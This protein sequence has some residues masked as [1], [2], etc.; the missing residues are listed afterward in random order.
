MSVF[1]SASSIGSLW[2]EEKK[3]IQ[4]FLES[5][6]AEQLSLS[7][8][9]H[10]LLSHT[11]HVRNLAYFVSLQIDEKFSNLV[12]PDLNATSA[13][14]HDHGKVLQ[15]P[16]INT[17]YPHFIR[18]QFHLAINGY[19]GIASL[20]GRHNF[21]AL[22]RDSVITLE[23]MILIYA[24]V[25]SRT[26]E[27][28]KPIVRVYRTLN[29]AYPGIRK[30]MLDSGKLEGD[31]IDAGFERLKQFEGL[32][33]QFGID[34]DDLSKLPD[35][36]TPLARQYYNP[37][38][39]EK[40][41]N[42]LHPKIEEFENALDQIGVVSI[43]KEIAE[44]ADFI[45]STIRLSVSGDVKAAERL[46][47]IDPV[48]T[49]RWIN[50][51]AL[52]SQKRVQREL[53][54]QKYKKI[55][56]DDNALYALRVNYLEAINKLQ[57][58]SDSRRLNVLRR[59]SSLFL[60]ENPLN[61]SV[62]YHVA[63]E[64]GKA[65]SRCETEYKIR[66]F[67]EMWEKFSS[68]PGNS[69]TPIAVREIFRGDNKLTREVINRMSNLQISGIGQH[70]LDMYA[71]ALIDFDTVESIREIIQDKKGVI[72]QIES[73]Q[74]LRQREDIR[75]AY[76]L[77]KLLDSPNRRVR[78]EASQGL[79]NLHQKST[80][81]VTKLYIEGLYDPNKKHDLQY[82]QII[83]ER[84]IIS[85][86]AIEIRALSQIIGRFN[87]GEDKENLDKSVEA[88]LGIIK[89]SRNREVLFHALQNIGISGL[90]PNLSTDQA[91]DI[92][93]Q[94]WSEFYFN[95]EVR[96]LIPYFL[97]EIYA[98]RTDLPQMQN[99]LSFLSNI[100]QSEGYPDSHLQ[101]EIGKFFIGLVGSIRNDSDPRIRFAQ[102]TILQTSKI[103][104]RLFEIL[105]YK[106]VNRI[107]KTTNLTVEQKRERLMG[108]MVRKFMSNPVAD[109]ILRYQTYKKLS[110][111]ELSHAQYSKNVVFYNGTFDPFHEG[112]ETMAKLASEFIGNVFVQADD[113]NPHKTPKPREVRNEIIRRSIAEQPGLYIFNDQKQFDFR[114]P[115][116]YSE[117]KRIFKDREVWLLI[118]EDRLRTSKYYS[119]YDHYVYRVPHVFTIR[120]SN[121]KPCKI[122]FRKGKIVGEVE[123]DLLIYL[124]SQNE[125]LEKIK[126]F[127]R[128]V[129]IGSPIN[130][131][132]TAIKQS[133]QEG[134]LRVADPVA[135]PIIAK[136]Y[137]DE[138]LIE[139]VSARVPLS[140]PRDLDI[141]RQDHRFLIM[142]DSSR[143][144]IWRK[145]SRKKSRPPK[146]DCQALFDPLK[147]FGYLVYMSVPRGKTTTILK[148]FDVNPGN[149][150]G[151]RRF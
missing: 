137:A 73:D 150:L 49:N 44:N 109:P 54:N 147:G 123:Q 2:R 122:E 82:H 127:A 146:D 132:S 17:P 42:R 32:L 77:S 149:I 83:L 14:F 59:I 15:Q 80:D 114:S 74:G 19:P 43:R 56:L 117:L 69:Y 121:F 1:E 3:R 87:Y 7:A 119:N 134:V 136:Y 131:S 104:P 30:M 135:L 120:S 33:R 101:Y 143:D 53:K 130:Y 140:N 47:L 12:D 112:T 36:F 22:I 102:E 85:N 78:I 92:L 111:S 100:V 79:V 106:Y 144:M 29:E 105:F 151:N 84:L 37:P 57:D 95:S 48:L 4:P 64:Y 113:F 67:N 145:L 21:G 108:N 9:E 39:P 40:S 70:G 107:I 68:D 25:R 129:I 116:E 61:D 71:E 51:L 50:L 94:L 11:L 90:V 26:L 58:L 142:P 34:V 98:E 18:S 103:N 28:S 141:A 63:K 60:V 66:I 93:R 6:I 124:Q 126:H 41:D 128:I 118:G 5:T 24:D 27:D 75:Y 16:K 55:V 20:A 91:T 86:D 125:L 46:A 99:D 89:T 115:Q 138:S 96:I 8:S 97:A 52:E 62:A 76:L 13:I 148:I 88:L 31:A 81:I 23:Q 45:R 10:D 110:E 35:K 65:I 38:I 139:H 72:F 133:I